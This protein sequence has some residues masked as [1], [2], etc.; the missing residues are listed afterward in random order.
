MLLWGYG[1][2][3]AIDLDVRTGSAIA[4]GFIASYIITSG[5]AWAILQP[6]LTSIAL[7]L[8]ALFSPGYR[9]R[10]GWLASLTLF[11]FAYNAAACLEVAIVNSLDVWRYCTVQFYFTLL[12]EVLAVWLGLET[13]IHWIRWGRPIQ[14]STPAE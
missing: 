4:L 7:G 12:A 6:L 8:L 9:A 2:W 1:L 14:T 5:F 13:V 11:L 3:G 10:F